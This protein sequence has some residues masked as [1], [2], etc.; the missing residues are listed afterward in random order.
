MLRFREDACFAIYGVCRTL[1]TLLLSL[2][3]FLTWITGFYSRIPA[4]PRHMYVKIFAV[5]HSGPGIKTLE[6][7]NFFPRFSKSCYSTSSP[8]LGLRWGGVVRVLTAA[9]CYARL[10][11]GNRKLLKLFKLSGRRYRGWSLNAK[12]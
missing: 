6:L 10:F 11:Q 12:R 7:R 4:L 8:Q 1:L 2:F 9:S 3:R 5:A